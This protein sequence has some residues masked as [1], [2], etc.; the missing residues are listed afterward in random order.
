MSVVGRTAV[1]IVGVALT[2]LLLVFAGGPSRPHR[3]GRRLRPTLPRLSSV[4]LM[5][6]VAA[7]MAVALASSVA[8]T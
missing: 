5:S 4:N 3:A 8:L 1:A 7:V 2:W 6:Y